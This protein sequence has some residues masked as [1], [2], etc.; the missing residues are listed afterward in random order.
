MVLGCRGFHGDVLTVLKVLKN[1]LKVVYVLTCAIVC[2]CVCD[3]CV[4]ARARVRACVRVCMCVRMH[5]CVCTCVQSVIRSR[6]PL[7][8]HIH[9]SSTQVCPL[10]TLK[11]GIVLSE[12]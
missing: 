2:V 7:N 10:T 11:G 8:T 12:V 4:C 6:G 1:Q 5:V 3:V 9:V